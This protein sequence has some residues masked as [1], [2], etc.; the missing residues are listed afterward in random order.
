MEELSKK[1]KQCAISIINK[2]IEVDDRVEDSEIALLHEYIT[3][4]NLTE[5]DVREASLLNKTDAERILKYMTVNQKQWLLDAIMGVAAVDNDISED[6]ITYI[7][8]FCETAGIDIIK[9]LKY[10]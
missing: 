7:C 10:A 2:I 3:L 8:A 4:L 1:G 5:E 6:E 9:S